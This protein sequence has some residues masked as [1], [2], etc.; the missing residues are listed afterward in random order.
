MFPGATP[1]DEDDA[2]VVIG[3]PLDHTTTFYP[4]ARFGPERIRHHARHFDDYDHV[5]GQHFSDLKVGDHG[6]IDAWDDT[7]DYLEYL[8]SILSG[9]ILDGAVP[10]VLGG[11]HTVSIAGVQA[12][13]A[14]TFVSIDAHL[15]LRDEYDG[16]PLNH[17]TTTRRALE[18]VDEAVIIGAR[19]GA[20][21]EWERADEPD[22]TVVTPD[23]ADSWEPSELGDV[24]LSVDIDGIDPSAAPGTGTPEPFGLAPTTVHD[25][26]TRLATQAIGFDVVEVND[27]DNGQAATLAGKLLRRFVY[28]HSIER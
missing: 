22:V 17:A 21:E 23:D 5:T 9:Y 19:T 20:R 24:Y 4:G 18:H 28:A 8:R 6:D 13:E 7:E 11:E 1:P 15:D 2:Y 16:N 14:S 12:T 27:R 25:L 3:A 26:V 10:L